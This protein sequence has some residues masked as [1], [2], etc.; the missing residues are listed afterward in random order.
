MPDDPQPWR[1]TQT[2]PDGTRCPYPWRLS[3]W[4]I[5]MC[6]GCTFPAGSPATTRPEGWHDGIPPDG[7]DD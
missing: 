4:G 2:L 1:C 6:K 3:L 5:R 7:A